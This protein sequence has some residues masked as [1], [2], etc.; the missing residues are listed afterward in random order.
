MRH[1]VPS[2]NV[3]QH[4]FNLHLPTQNCV[5][6]C[7]EQRDSPSLKDLNK[8]I[9]S[10]KSTMRTGANPILDL[11][12]KGLLIPTAQVSFMM[13]S[14][15]LGHRLHSTSTGKK[16]SESSY[17]RSQ[18]WS[19]LKHM[20]QQHKILFPQSTELFPCHRLTHLFQ[21]CTSFKQSAFLN[22]V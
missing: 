18:S 14:C 20:I 19:G 10:A 7:D 9:P 8:V 15:H 6:E 3:L 5:R 2:P 21:F 22:S 17:F 12:F 11:T 4:F 1:C 13:K 16:L